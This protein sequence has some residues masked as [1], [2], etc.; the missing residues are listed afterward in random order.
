MTHPIAISRL[1][2]DGT[3]NSCHRMACLC[4]RSVRPL[5]AIIAHAACLA[6]LIRPFRT[7]RRREAEACCRLPAE[8][9]SRMFHVHRVHR[10]LPGGLPAMLQR[11]EAIAA[12]QPDAETSGGGVV[13]RDRA[14]RSLPQLLCRP[15]YEPRLRFSLSRGPI[16]SSRPSPG[17]RHGSIKPRIR[18]TQRECAASARRPTKL[19]EGTLRV[20]VSQ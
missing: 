3:E 11:G 7:C 2:S 5:G 4:Y 20:S 12:M 9:E 16:R 10:C 19:V 14:L 8:R 15:A 17:V 18:C 6:V 1:S 13:V